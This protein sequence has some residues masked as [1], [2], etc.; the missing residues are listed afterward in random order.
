MTTPAFEERII[1][2]DPT[3]PG[4]SY[5]IFARGRGIVKPGTISAPGDDRRRL[6]AGFRRVLIRFT[7]RVLV[8]EDPGAERV[9]RIRDVV[10]DLA[11]VATEFGIEVVELSRADV[12]SVFPAART[13]QERAAALAARFPRMAELQPR[14]RQGKFGEDPRMNYFDALALIVTFLRTSADLPRAPLPPPAKPKGD[15]ATAC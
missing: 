11:A 1:G 5:V 3:S 15:R 13:K 4:L 2:V 6:L 14:D 7:P 8:L 10:A 9:E 12:E